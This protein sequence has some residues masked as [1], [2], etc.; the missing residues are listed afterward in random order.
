MYS[1][2]LTVTSFSTVVAVAVLH[3][4]FEASASRSFL[5]VT[6]VESASYVVVSSVFTSWVAV[7]CCIPSVAADALVVVASVDS[8]YSLLSVVSGVVV[9]LVVQHPSD[10]PCVFLRVYSPSY[11]VLLRWRCACLMD[12]VCCMSDLY[13]RWKCCLRVLNSNYCC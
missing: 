1:P 10:L 7:S 11:F 13:D 2:H 9:P 3:I 5:S 4:A 12:A 6:V 8:I